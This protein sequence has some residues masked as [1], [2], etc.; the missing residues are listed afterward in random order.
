MLP[1][2]SKIRFLFYLL[3]PNKIIL[4][5]FKKHT[6]WSDFVSY[7]QFSGRVA[8]FNVVQSIKNNSR[9]EIALIPNYICN[10]VNIAVLK[11]GY[12]IETYSLDDYLE[13][14]IE[15]LIKTIEEKKITLLFVANIFGSSALIDK[16]EQNQ[17]L[18][19]LLKEKKITLIIDICQDIRLLDSLKMKWEIPIAVVIS[20]NNKS[21]PGLMGGSL[22]CNFPVALQTQRMSVKQELIVW[23][24]FIISEFLYKKK[25]ENDINE[26][27][28]FSKCATFPYQISPYIPM[29]LQM[30]YAVLGI[31]NLNYYDKQKK[32]I[33]DDNN[34][35]N[36]IHK[37][38]FFKTSPFLIFNTDNDAD[39]IL[40]RMKLRKQK[41]SYSHPENSDESYKPNLII[42]NNKG[43]DDFN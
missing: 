30:I 40:Y 28:D 2:W 26:N 5:K 9:N 18:T 22:I 12:K 38:K 20:F 36:K 41:N 37:T 7:P 4:Y 43:F 24:L 8:I 13:P 42:F 23:K 17:K 14:N 1:V 32:K 3:L 27:Y 35:A 11:A 31:E 25:K 34:I 15:E 10:V 29:K 19:S 33:F 39:F 21:F 16:I 6:E